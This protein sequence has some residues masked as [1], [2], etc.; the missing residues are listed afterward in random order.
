[1]EFFDRKQ[2]VID[3][4]L[5]PYGKY[6]LSKGKL[7]PKFYAFFDKDVYIRFLLWRSRV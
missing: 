6:L 4:Q 2:E 7:R 1:M 5:T 3:I